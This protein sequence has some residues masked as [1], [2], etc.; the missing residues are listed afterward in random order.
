MS[1]PAIATLL[2]LVQQYSPSGQ[3][4]GAVSW[5]VGRMQELRFTQAFIDP[6]G[7][8]VG[9]MGN[10]GGV[11]DN[12]GG[13]YDNA[14]SV[15]GSGSRQMLLVGHIDTVPGE[16]PVRIEQDPEGDRLHGRGS[17]DAKGAL[18]AFVEAVAAL[19]PVEGWQMVV[20]G[21]VG[22]ERDSLGAR[23]IAPHYQPSYAIFGEPSGWERVTLGYK[24]CAWAEISV[25]RPAGHSASGQATA[26]EAAVAAWQAVQ[27]WAAEFNRGRPRL[28]DQVLPGLQGMSSAEDGFS[29]TAR[30]E[31]MTRLPLDLDPGAWYAQLGQLL[32]G[33]QV[34]PR[35]F[36]IPAYRGE[37]NTPLVGA[38][39]GAI[40]AQGGQP[41]LVH[42]TGTSDLNVLAPQWGCP[43]LVYGPGDSK[44]DH[45]PQE[46]ISLAEYLKAV[47]V[48]R[49]VLKRL[50]GITGIGGTKA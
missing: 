50:V 24:G 33:E 8:A 6:A 49:A 27:A 43:A 10:A 37:K 36:A 14:V 13:V 4:A 41:A 25:Q 16:I 29:Q 47:A 21:A 34:E 48:L 42:K 7:N 22:E 45:T 26:C 38:F 18:A 1:D 30:L 5:L 35:G 28:F 19:G 17:V 12:A 11:Y 39:L 3:E 9:V 44:L 46:Q 31:I 32:G 40:R 2:G 20:V 15:M 23:T